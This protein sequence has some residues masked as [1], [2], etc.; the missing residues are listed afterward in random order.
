MDRS[1]FE[2]EAMAWADTVYRVARWMV[3]DPHQ[4]DDLV[5]ET[6][7]RAFKGFKSFVE[8]TDCR[9]WLLRIL[10]NTAVDMHRRKKLALVE[11]DEST[12]VKES[13]RNAERD[14]DGWGTPEA[15]QALLE[16]TADDRLFGAVQSVPEPLRQSFCL[17]VLGDCSYR[18][19][20]EL[21][22]CAEGTVKSRVSRACGQIRSVLSEKK[23]T[24]RAKTA[25]VGTANVK[26]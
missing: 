19:A 24:P 9:S 7:L 17:V 13:A 8:G 15:W 4:A 14:A 20:A 5:Q 26:A 16:R 1:S 2:Q 11:L 25:T 3:S 22:G 6:Y 10:R 12:D 23:P 21:L 18:E